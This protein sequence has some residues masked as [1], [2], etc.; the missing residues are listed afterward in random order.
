MAALGCQTLIGADFGSARAIPEAA[1]P[2]VCKL[3]RVPTRPPNLPSAADSVEFTVVIDQLDLGDEAPDGGAT[4]A[5][6]YDLDGLCTT[7]SGPPSCRQFA[8][9]DQAPAVDG[10]GGR[11]DGIGNLFKAQRTVLVGN[12]LISSSEENAGLVSGATA[13]PG[14][15]RI[16]G[17]S[18]LASDD[19][20]QVELF[21]AAAY[22]AV[23]RPP[24]GDAGGALPRFDETDHWPLVRETLLDPDGDAP[25]SSQRDDS[26][27]VIG[28]QLVASFDKLRLPMHNVFVDVSKATLTGDLARD[29]NTGRWTLQ[30]G[31]LAARLETRTLLAFAPLATIL[32]AGVALCKDDALNYDKVKRFMC[33]S[34]DLPAVD[35]D[36]KSDCMYTSLGI[37]FQ[38][39]PASL[40]PLVDVSPLPDP[41]PPGLDPAQ[42]TCDDEFQ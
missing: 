16:R 39:S 15:L 13:P 30:N 31:T 24:G 34:A 4:P 37:H 38:T 1:A 19:R 10:P 17:F 28:G 40:G 29:K 22:G 18:G 35:G 12:A 6:G 32:Q 11:D 2:A 25:E 33:Q 42:D 20:V 3:E 9:L 23:P 36:P 7:K 14:V 27:F 26:A 41:C 21:Q 8:W 5:V